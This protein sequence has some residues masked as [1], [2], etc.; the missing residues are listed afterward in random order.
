MKVEVSEYIK[1][2]QDTIKPD[3]ITMIKNPLV[4]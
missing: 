4:E 2:I 1:T 3:S